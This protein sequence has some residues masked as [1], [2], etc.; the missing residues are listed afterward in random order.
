MQKT[1]LKKNVSFQKALLRENCE[2][3][4]DLPR[5]QSNLFLINKM[6]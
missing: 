1:G 5:G 6:S 4:S 3:L 2:E